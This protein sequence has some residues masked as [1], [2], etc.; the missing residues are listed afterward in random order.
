MQSLYQSVDYVF[1][2][3][4]IWGHRILSSVFGKLQFTREELREFLQIL[5][6]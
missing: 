1:F 5:S 4:S 6:W 3:I 2:A